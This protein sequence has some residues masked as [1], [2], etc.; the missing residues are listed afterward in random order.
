VQHIGLG[1]EPDEISHYVGYAKPDPAGM[2]SGNSRDGTR[3]K[4]VLA[5]HRTNVQR[6]IR[7]AY[8]IGLLP[9]PRTIDLADPMLV[10]TIVRARGW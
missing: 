9:G 5:G 10:R 8:T 3:V 1:E 4:T 7:Q 2:S 6:V